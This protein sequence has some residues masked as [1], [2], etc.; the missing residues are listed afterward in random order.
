[1]ASNDVMAEVVSPPQ[2]GWWARNW[3]WAAPSGCLVLI[4]LPLGC[5]LGI[6]GG[7]LMVLKNSEPY[8]MA[9]ERVRTDPQVIQKLGEPVQE[10]SW[11]PVGSVE[12][13]NDGG[14]AILNFDV[15]GPKG[16]AHVMSQSKRIGGKWGIT[17]LEVRFAD[18]PPISLQVE[19]EAGLEEAPKWSPGK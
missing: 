11:F 17:S 12:T 16:K 7:G 18:G 8:Q 15:A 10:A 9:L 1:M 14:S 19:A 4:L 6:L 2:R 13:N 5:C 3:L